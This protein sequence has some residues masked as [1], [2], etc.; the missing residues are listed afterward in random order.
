[1][2]VSGFTFI[3]NGLSLGYPILESLQSISDLCDEVVV[4]VCFDDENLKDDDGTFEYLSDNL[5]QNKYKFIKSRWTENKEYGDHIYSAHTNYALSKCT[6]EICQYIQGDEAIHE[7]DLATIQQGFKDLYDRKD[8]DGLIYKYIHFYGNVDT[9]KFTRQIYKREVRAIKKSNNVFSWKDA[10]GFRY[11]DGSK[12]RAKEI[13][14]SIYHYGWARKENIM[15][16]KIKVMATHYHGEDYETKEE[17]QY[18]RIWGVQ[19]FKG[20]HPKIMEKWVK[21]NRNEVDMMKL[22]RAYHM[23]DLDLMISDFIESITGY[24]IGEYRNFKVVK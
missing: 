3:K 16:E 2:K 18:K 11:R 14:A 23:G 12:I 6:G 7:K 10:Q 1:M 21:E 24:R 15:K 13:D 9:F 19:P 17:F 20:T 22:P 8:I 4:N 5:N